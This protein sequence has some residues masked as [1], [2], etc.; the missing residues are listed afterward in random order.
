MSDECF[1]WVFPWMTWQLCHLFDKLHSL[2]VGNQFISLQKQSYKH[3]DKGQQR[4]FMKASSYDQINRKKLELSLKKW[5]F[6][7]LQYER[8]FFFYRT[9]IYCVWMDSKFTQIYV[10][11]LFTALLTLTSILILYYWPLS[12]SFAIAKT[13]GVPITITCCS[14]SCSYNYNINPLTSNTFA[15]TSKIIWC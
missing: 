11:Q 5:K 6:L 7:F 8:I 13:S 4:L 3:F 12:G 14:F 10:Q 1:F 2:T 9:T 15:L